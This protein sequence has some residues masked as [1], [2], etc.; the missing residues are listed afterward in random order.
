MT[1]GGSA[2]HFE[3]HGILEEHVVV[4]A[5]GKV[6]RVEKGLLHCE[7]LPCNLLPLLII[8][9]DLNAHLSASHWLDLAASNTRDKSVDA[10]SGASCIE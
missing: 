3:A 2:Y 1:A 4:L 10:H 7:A 5:D 9:V 6:M 8:L